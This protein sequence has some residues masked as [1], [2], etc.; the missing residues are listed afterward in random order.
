[1]AYFELIIITVLGLSFGSLITLLSWRIPRGEAICN[2]RSKCPNCKMTLGVR[3]LFPLLSWVFSKGKCRGCNVKIHWR[4]PLTEIFTATIFL[5]IYFQY[6]LGFGGLFLGIFAVL[7]ITMFII[8]FEHY[9]IP[10]SLQW[11]MG[12]LG[13]AYSLGYLELSPAS[14]IVSSFF[15]LAIGLSLKY[16]FIYLRKKDGLGMGDVKFLFVAGLWISVADF[17]PLMFFAGV[18]GIIT[19]IIWRILG[20]GERFPFAPALGASVFVM[21]LYPVSK[22]IFLKFGELIA[23]FMV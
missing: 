19:A 7:L 10:D 2:T 20:F 8:D 18:F 16:G 1:M 12:L 22:D 14:L 4:Y 17:I 13:S 6:G 15:G 3:D 11:A 21:L 9:I 23:G 5:A